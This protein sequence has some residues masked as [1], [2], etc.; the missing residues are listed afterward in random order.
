MGPFGRL[1]VP[2]VLIACC[3]PRL[4]RAGAV[5]HAGDLV[6]VDSFVYPEPAPAV[7]RVDP[8]TFDTTRI[9]TGGPLIA[10]DRIAVDQSGTIWVTDRVSGLVAIDPATGESRIVLA[11][12][13]FGGRV[14]HGV[15]VDPAGGLFVSA[16]GDPEGAL[17][18]MTL[19]PAAATPRPSA[20]SSPTRAGSRWRKAAASRHGR[21][22][23]AGLARGGVPS[24]IWGAAPLDLPFDVAVGTDGW[25]WC[26]QWGGLS[27]RGGG[28]VRVRADGS[29]AE[30]VDGSDRSQGIAATPLGTIYLVDCISVSLDCYAGYRH[31][32]RYGD[33]GGTRYLPIGALAV[34]P[35]LTVPARPTTWGELKARYR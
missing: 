16:S 15:C 21:R 22:V 23:V 34:V 3:A 14:P 20:L 10:P 19:D 18:H 29:A 33:P 26:A 31:V 4:A 8:A 17:L 11:L 35:E 9:A 28:F 5:L 6:A 1:I 13:A 30:V 24:L 2:L 27:R 25:A 32:L 7:W 12:A